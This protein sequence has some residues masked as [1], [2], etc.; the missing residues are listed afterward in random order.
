MT[1]QL[2]LSAGRE[3]D[4]DRL[5]AVE[6]CREVI[7]RSFALADAG[8]RAEIADL[9]VAGGV[10][11]I[12]GETARGQEEIRALFAARDKAGRRTAH[13]VTTMTV[14]V[15]SESEIRVRSVVLLY[16]LSDADPTTP[17]VLTSVDDLLVKDGE[18]W[19]LSNRV[20]SVLSRRG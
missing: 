5:A 4:S 10:Q 12:D 9:F 19:R 14:D 16:L 8:R 18:V 11:S 7:H 20:T 13:A 15:S 3:R 1:D 6:A 2:V 17:N